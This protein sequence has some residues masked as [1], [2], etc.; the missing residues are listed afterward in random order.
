M[1]LL[2][3]LVRQADDLGRHGRYGRAVLPFNWAFMLVG[4]WLV[5]A[6]GLLCCGK[7]R[8][9][10]RERMSLNVK[11]KPCVKQLSKHRCEAS[12]STPNSH[13]LRYLRK[14]LATENAD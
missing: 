2:W 9:L 11:V 4:P 3:S 6:A 12:L 5:V 1:G 7:P 10:P 13:L 14:L 8:R